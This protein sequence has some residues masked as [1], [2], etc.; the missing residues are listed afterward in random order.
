MLFICNKGHIKVTTAN[1]F[2]YGSDISYF[3][4]VKPPFNI[5]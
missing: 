2:I 4:K 1:T 5:G 3:N